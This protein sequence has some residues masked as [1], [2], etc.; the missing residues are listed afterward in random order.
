MNVDQSQRRA[1]LSWLFVGALLVLC[2]VLGVLQYRW[3]GEVSLA[4]RDRLRVSLQA[5][6]DRLSQDFNSEI[7]EACRAL[8]PANPSEAELAAHFEQWKKTAGHGQI[9]GAVA[10]AQPQTRASTLR[11]LNL[12]TGAFETTAW[13]AEW[14]AIR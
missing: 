4:A 2:G 14:K 12:E 5:S 7:A 10:I 6:L 8:V 9:F 3:I 13:P 11:R 1:V